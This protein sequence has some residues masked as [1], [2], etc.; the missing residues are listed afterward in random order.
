LKSNGPQA[1]VQILETHNYQKLLAKVVKVL[2]V[3]SV[4]PHNKVNLVKIGIDYNDFIQEN[5]LSN[6][7]FF[8]L[9]KMLLKHFRDTSITIT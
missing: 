8:V 3:L 7:L 6:M 2:K 9:I 5:L 1:L 4:C